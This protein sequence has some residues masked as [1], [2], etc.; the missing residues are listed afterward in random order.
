MISIQLSPI[1]DHVYK[2]YHVLNRRQKY[3]HIKICM[4]EQKRIDLVYILH[5]LVKVNE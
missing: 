3:I 5:I 1:V 4:K 2:M